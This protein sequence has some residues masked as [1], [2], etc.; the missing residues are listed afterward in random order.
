MYI[1]VNLCFYWVFHTCRQL[2]LCF[3][4]IH[5]SFLS[6]QV[7]LHPSENHCLP[8]TSSVFFKQCPLVLFSRVTVCAWCRIYYCSM[9]GLS[10]IASL[11]KS[12][13]SS[14]RGHQLT[15]SQLR[16][17]LH[18]PLHYLCWD[19]S[20]L[21]ALVRAVTANGNSYCNGSIFLVNTVS[22]NIFT[23]SYSLTIVPFPLLQWPL[24]LKIK[25]GVGIYDVHV[26]TQSLI[27]WVLTSCGSQCWLMG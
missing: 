5:T 11:K 18:E 25:G 15:I 16:V 13:L 7:L 23:I 22:L 1:G 26:Y 17:G 20:W 12:D 14:P 21:L 9:G 27:L 10:R 2:F 19:F 6:L 4:H 3:Y 24:N 8:S